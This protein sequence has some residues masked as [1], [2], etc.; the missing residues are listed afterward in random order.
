MG[1]LLR[2]PRNGHFQQLPETPNIHVE[3]WIWV[4][5]LTYALAD[6]VPL[7]NGFCQLQ[8]RSKQLNILTCCSRCNRND[9][10]SGS[11]GD[12]RGRSLASKRER[13]QKL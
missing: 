3:D 7:P 12:I 5:N 13:Y 4:S 2:R 9:D 6:I 1:S 8:M 11:K 10:R